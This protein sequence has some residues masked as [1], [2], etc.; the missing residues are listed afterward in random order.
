[1]PSPQQSSAR[2]V[3]IESLGRLSEEEREKLHGPGWATFAARKVRS[4]REARKWVIALGT[5]MGLFAIALPTTA[6]YHYYDATESFSILGFLGAIAA[7]CLFAAAQMGWAVYIYMNWRHQLRTYEG[8]RALGR[9]PSPDA[10]DD[11]RV[12]AS[13]ES[14]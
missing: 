2:D 11:P 7:A 12:A 9:D 14:A 6:F 10:G 13:E 8:L 3:L 1:M 5:T 4:L